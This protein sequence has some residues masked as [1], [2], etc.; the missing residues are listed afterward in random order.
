MSAAQA[1]ATDHTGT[2]AA[3]DGLSGPVV[4]EELLASL[5]DLPAQRPVAARMVQLTHDEGI[6]AADLAG[7]AAA[8][9]TVTARILRLANS[10]YYGLSGRVR[11]LTFAVTVVGFTTVR[12]IA[13][14][15]AAGV[16]DPR[17]VPD[18]FW[19]RSASTAVAAGELA[20]RFRLTSPDAFCLGLL[21]GIGQALLHRADP[22]AY[23]P[24]LAGAADRAALVAAERARYGVSHVA[25]S[26]AALTAWSFPTDMAA[27][28]RPLDT[29]PL[30]QPADGVDATTRCLLVAREV[31]DR[32]TGWGPGPLE[33]SH[34]SGG[35][36]DEVDVATLARRVPALAA[37]LVRAVQS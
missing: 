10:A 33:V 4:L 16:D 28:I 31:A 27:A 22:D 1:P 12:T 19:E 13:L 17:A 23:G 26:A 30:G 35:R 11:T 15:A 2:D 21:T 14:S 20:R 29:W 37:D 5:D 25:V 8:D 3:G 9:A 6:S 34:M 24:L 7:V 32:L 18:G 36:V